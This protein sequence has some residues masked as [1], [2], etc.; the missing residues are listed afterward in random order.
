MQINQP[1][2]LIWQILVNLNLSLN[3]EIEK[4]T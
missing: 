2:L 1:M 3:I 4:E